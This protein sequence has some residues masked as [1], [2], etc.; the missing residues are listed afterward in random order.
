LRLSTKDVDVLAIGKVRPHTPHGVIPGVVLDIAAISTSQDFLRG[1]HPV[2][3]QTFNK[4]QFVTVDNL[5]RSAVCDCAE[6]KK[7]FISLRL[8]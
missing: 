6:C 1:C 8:V 2:K 3:F 7:T 5:R 4:Q